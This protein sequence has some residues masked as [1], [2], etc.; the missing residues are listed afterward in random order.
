MSQTSMGRS[1]AMDAILIQG[2]VLEC[3][4]GIR[5]EERTQPQPLRV[6]VE[7]DVDVS[8]AGRSGRIADT[9]DYDA[10]TELVTAWLRYR[11]PQ[12]LEAAA[13][14]LAVLLL[15]CAPRVERVA[16]TLTKPRALSGR[17]EAAAVR[18]ARARA[19]LGEEPLWEGREALFER[20]VLAPGAALPVAPNA[21][22]ELLVVL[23][24][25]ITGAETLVRA[26][27][28]LPL[29]RPTQLTA[30]PAGASLVR[31]VRLRTP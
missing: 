31:H 8:L 3:I 25:E 15:A 11:R 19:S 24:G 13:E 4:V 30:G 27:A 21:L 6:D 16:L 23:A 22:R 26:G 1:A 20:C 9:C 29:S 7:L 14:E 2:L 28:V 17:A 18:V 10:L 5:P 12:L